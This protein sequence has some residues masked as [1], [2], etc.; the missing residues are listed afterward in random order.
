[1][2][3]PIVQQ[4]IQLQHK[5]KF[6]IPTAVPHAA[7]SAYHQ[8]TISNLIQFLHAIAGSPPVKTWCKTIDNNFFLTWPGLI[9]QAVRKHLPKS[10]ATAMGHI[11]MIRKGIRS[12]NKPTMEEI[13]EEVLIRRGWK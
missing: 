2:V 10:E 6:K 1:L 3:P 12:T 7:N 5:Y 11:H 8:K 13:T 4:R 9:S